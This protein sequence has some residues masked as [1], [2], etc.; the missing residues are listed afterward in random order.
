MRMGSSVNEG[1]GIAVGKR[2][3]LS[4]AVFGRLV[5]YRCS[6]REGG[7]G[8][9]ALP[10]LVST[11]RGL[12]GCSRVVLGCFQTELVLTKCV[13]RSEAGC[14]LERCGV[15][16][17]SLCDIASSFPEVIRSSLEGKMRSMACAVVLSIYKSFLVSRGGLLRVVGRL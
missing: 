3:R 17:E 1:G 16:G 8:N 4:D 6:V 2:A 13:P 5:L 14:R 10:R 11:V 7:T 9:L 15:G 12:L